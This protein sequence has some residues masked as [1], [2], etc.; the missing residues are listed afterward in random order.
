M[1]TILGVSIDTRLRIY[2]EHSPDDSL[3]G[4]EHMKAVGYC[5]IYT[6]RRDWKVTAHV[7]KS[8]HTT[9]NRTFWHF[10]NTALTS[11][12]ICLLEN[13]PFYTWA[14]MKTGRQVSAAQENNNF[15]HFRTH[16]ICFSPNHLSSATTSSSQY[17]G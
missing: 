11:P 10:P 7:S 8:K 1:F 6:H 2:S 13:E 5:S 16:L 3:R 9:R 14:K 17:A 4:S 15:L 12:D